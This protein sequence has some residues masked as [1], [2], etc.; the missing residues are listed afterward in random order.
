MSLFKPILVLLTVVFLLSCS[1][2]ETAVL[3]TI[4]AEAITAKDL[5]KAF[6]MQELQLGLLPDPRSPEKL[7]RRK[8]AILDALIEHRILLMQARRH[9]MTIDSVVLQGYLARLKQGYDETDF[10]DQMESRGLTVREWEQAQ[11]EKFL[12]QNW[13]RKYIV[14]QIQVTPDE[15]KA[16]YRKHKE[17][18]IRPEQVKALHIFVNTKEEAAKLRQMIEAGAEFEQV[19]RQYSKGPEGAEGGD[20]GYFTKGDYPPVFTETCFKL[21]KGQLSQ[22]IKSD[23]G[24]HLF[25]LVDRR[26]K[27]KR[28]LKEATEDVRRILTEQRIRE[29]ISVTLEQLRQ[30]LPIQVNEE[31]LAE[32]T[33]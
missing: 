9:G 17:A 22:V 2:S 5:K 10:E 30:E 19:A 16:Y 12:V 20:L 4:D 25:K 15:I 3:A 21:K 33:L 26:K 11:Q 6:R 13:I 32:V 29:N 7:Q 23:Y 18:F 28:S 24:Y 8:R 27:K 1:G 14:S 31:A